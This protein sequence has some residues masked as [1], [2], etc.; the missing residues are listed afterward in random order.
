MKPYLELS[1]I[2]GEP[3]LEEKMQ[4][5]ANRLKIYRK[6]MSL[7]QLQ[8]ADRSGV[9]YGSVKR[10]ERTGE[11]SLWGLWRICIAL[12]CDDQLDSLFTAPKLT[13]EDIRNGR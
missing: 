6:R 7:T 4:S 13:A 12:G 2:F 10:F 11:I 5:L 9:S 8:L 3:S 1:D